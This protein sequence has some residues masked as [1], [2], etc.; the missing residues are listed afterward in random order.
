MKDFFAKFTF[1]S[2]QLPEVLTTMLFFQD[3]H[4]YL[5]SLL[6]RFFSGSTQLPEVLTTM[7]FSGSTQIPEVL[8]TMFCSGSTQ[9]PEMPGSGL[10]QEGGYISR[11]G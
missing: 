1:G 8:T 4:S 2:T 7:F 10:L 5:K 11:Q 3:L 9:L 6:Q